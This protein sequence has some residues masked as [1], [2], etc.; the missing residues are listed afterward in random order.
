MERDFCTAGFPVL[1]EDFTAALDQLHDAHSQAV[2]APKVGCWGTRRGWV[3]QNSWLKI[4]DLSGLCSDTLL[5]ALSFHS[6]PQLSVGN[7][8]L[9]FSPSIFHPLGLEF[10]REA[11]GVLIADQ[12]IGWCWRGASCWG[13]RLP[14]LTEISSSTWPGLRLVR[15]FLHTCE[16]LRLD[17]W[18]WM[19]LELAWA[20]L[21]DMKF[22]E[23]GVSSGKVTWRV[24]ENQQ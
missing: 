18:P 14:C 6:F 2:G 7:S 4:A 23:L 1:E 24:R 20:F 13:Q 15:E 8:P 22:E 3:L 9:D 10:V 21:I 12:L 11:L 5:P 17:P 19:L 16:S